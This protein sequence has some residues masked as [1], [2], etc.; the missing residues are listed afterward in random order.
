[1]QLMG[2]TAQSG[3]AAQ[4]ARKGTSMHGQ[5][6]EASI[7]S[8]SIVRTVKHRFKR[9]FAGLTFSP[10]VAFFFVRT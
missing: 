3:A 9:N 6:I 4:Y 1:M 2:A 10:T 5:A 7:S 8:E